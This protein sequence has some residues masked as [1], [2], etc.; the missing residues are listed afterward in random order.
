MTTFRCL[1]GNGNGSEGSSVAK[2][3][4]LREPGLM[5]NDA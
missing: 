4:A 5:R 3:K 1:L 2:V